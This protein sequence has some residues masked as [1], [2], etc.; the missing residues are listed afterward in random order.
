MHAR[1]APSAAELRRFA[2][3]LAGAVAL[4]FGVLIPWLWGRAAPWWPWAVA[5][6]LAA[7]GLALPLRLAPLYRGWMRFGAVIGA[8]NTR[9][10][11]TLAFFLV[12]TPTGM[13]MRLLGRDPMRRRFEREAPSYRTPST[14]PARERMDRPF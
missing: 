6:A 7:S 2:C 8:F 5:A 12:L 3:L 9:V 1:S 4:C 11:L 14:Q 10:L 13:L